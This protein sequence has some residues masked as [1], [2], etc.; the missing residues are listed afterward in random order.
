MSEISAYLKKIIEEEMINVIDFLITDLKRELIDQAH[1]LTGKLRDSIE[2]LP[3][4]KTSDATYCFVALENYYRI[5][6]EGITAATVRAKL[7][8]PNVRTGKTRSL[9]IEALIRFWKIK[10]GLSDK[11]AKSA[12]FALARKHSKEGFPT[13]K[14]WE[15][16]SNGRRLAFFSYVVENSRHV[17]K[18]EER[19]E[20]LLEDVSERILDKFKINVA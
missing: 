18:L 3:L 14:S 6:D 15:H 10:K 2:L 11:D 20:N 4:L 9:Y 12:A 17:D 7:Y 5:L 8:N 19:I 16:S 13:Q 1:I